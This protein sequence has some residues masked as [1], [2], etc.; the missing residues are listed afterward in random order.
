[1]VKFTLD[2]TPAPL[3][4]VGVGA[5]WRQTDYKENYYGRVNDKS[6]QYDA[7]VSWGDDR[8]RITGIGNWGKVEFEQDYRNTATVAGVPGNPSPD[9]PT[10]STNFNWSTNNTQDGWMAAVAVDWAPADKWTL[11][12]T[13][14][15]GK[16][17]RRR[18][19]HVGEHAGRRRLP[20][21]GRSSTTT[22]TTRSCSG[23]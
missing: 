21:A 22:P 8:F 23:S 4:F 16:T 7:T 18:G 1:M 9:G 11:N 15:Y 13:Y 6:Q 3:W 14:A 20:T 17:A 12:A 10:N 5:Q 19:L 2:W